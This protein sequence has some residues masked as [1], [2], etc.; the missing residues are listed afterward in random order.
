MIEQR[1]SVFDS[2]LL[3]IVIP[4]LVSMNWIWALRMTRIWNREVAVAPVMTLVDPAEPAVE[5]N[6][7]I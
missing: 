4:W 6:R 2:L 1:R 7:A 3:E 5:A